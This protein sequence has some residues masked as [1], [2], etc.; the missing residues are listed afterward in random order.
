MEMEWLVVLNDRV[1][2]LY[3]LA[4]FSLFL[5]GIQLEIWAKDGHSVALRVHGV[6]CGCLQGFHENV[7]KPHFTSLP[8]SYGTA[9]FQFR[10]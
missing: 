6:S 2:I 9:V 4:R 7:M 1:W 10:I 8:S 5:P 3:L